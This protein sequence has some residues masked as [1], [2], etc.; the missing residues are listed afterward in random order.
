MGGTL[1]PYFLQLDV[2]NFTEMRNLK[3][4]Q[5]NRKM[6]KKSK[7]PVLEAG[8]LQNRRF[9]DFGTLERFLMYICIISKNRRFLGPKI[10]YWRDYFLFP[11][12]IST[13]NF[14]ILGFFDFWTKFANFGPQKICT[15]C[16]ILDEIF[17]TREQNFL[18]K[19]N[20]LKRRQLPIRG[21]I[22]SK[23]SSWTE[24]W[25]APNPVFSPNLGLGETARY[26]TL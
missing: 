21:L 1:T 13:P 19:W 20:F 24:L 25:G 6:V 23:K 17:R 18:K 7:M 9:R 2:Q 12:T 11:H 22:Q 10:V 15:F 26:A 14:A 4:M 16:A 8:S 3:K 5:K